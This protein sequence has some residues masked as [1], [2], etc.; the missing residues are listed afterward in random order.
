MT[1]WG[2]SFRAY[3]V[4]GLVTE[5]EPG[6]FLTESGELVETGVLPKSAAVLTAEAFTP[7]N[8]TR[9]IAGGSFAFLLGAGVQLWFDYPNPYLSGEQIRGRMF[10][11]GVGGTAAWGIGT[12]TALG[13]GWLAT[14]PGWAWAG[15]WAGPIGIVVGFGAGFLWFG[16]IQP[17]AFKALGWTPKR[18]LAPLR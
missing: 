16:F 4:R 3:T 5:L 18:N 2:R 6:L 12:G 11:A 9:F 15:A 14:A 7:V 10:V 17:R 1:G 8:I 13:V